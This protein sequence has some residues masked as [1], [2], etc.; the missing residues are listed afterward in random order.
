M[1]RL[2]CWQRSIRKDQLTSIIQPVKR[3]ESTG[4]F[5]LNRHFR[6]LAIIPRLLGYA[7][8]ERG[9]AGKIDLPLRSW[10][11]TYAQHKWLEKNFPD[12]FA[13]LTVGENLPLFSG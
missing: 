8:R 10:Q 3:P 7:C 12:E 9:D 2:R 11:I 6:K 13:K 5:C 4:R 1:P